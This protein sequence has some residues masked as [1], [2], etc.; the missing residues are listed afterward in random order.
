MDKLLAPT[1][2]DLKS[3]V[4]REYRQRQEQA[5]KERILNPR[6]R[7]IGVDKEALD[8]HVKEKQ[9]QKLL[10]QKEELC[11]AAEQNRLFDEVDG[12]LKK[13]AE[14]KLREQCEMNE[15]RNRYQ[16]KEET[17]EFDLND[18]HRLR[19]MPSSDGL[20]WLG[21]DAENVQR[22]KLQR[23]QQKSWL[24]QQID[25]KN[26]LKKNFTEA[27]QAFESTALNQDI[28]IKE[29]EFTESEQRRKIQLDTAKFNFKLM[30]MQ[31][32]KKM[33]D[34]RRE[35]QDDLAEIM[36]N[37]SSDM[38]LESKEDVAS[39]LFG[40]NR[41]S[42]TTY[43]GM[44]E[45]QLNEI[46]NEQLRQIQEKKCQLEEMK[47]SDVVY[48]EAVKNQ[49]NSL[50]MEEQRVQRKRQQS[51]ADQNAVNAL[52]FEDQKQRNQHL[53]SEVYK[54]TPTEEYFEQFNKSSR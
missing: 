39:S 37:L 14:E 2:D 19:K 29:K 43:R 25:E 53:N 54:F 27:E 32:A 34:K 41:F 7:L 30:Q 13:I 35:R 26:E 45:H 21:F 47:K 9:Y 38:L 52:L 3:M 49:M 33:E 16:R 46:R 11:F 12:Q 5:R 17:R 8:E 20:N 23:E 10:E 24:Q 15:F 42:T 44:T 6:V 28:L 22:V 18:P 36:N 1:K 48:N 51:Q 4:K 31:K 50:E 40:E